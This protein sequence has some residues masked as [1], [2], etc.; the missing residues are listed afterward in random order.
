VESARLIETSPIT[1][2]LNSDASFAAQAR[3]FAEDGA[4]TGSGPLPPAVD[5]TTTY[6]VYW[7]LKNSLHDLERIS[8]SVNL[9]PDVAWMGNTG[10]DIGAVSF[11]ETTRL[12]TWNMEKV[13]TSIP[14]IRAW[15]DLAI[16]PDANDVGTFVKLTNVTAFEGT[17]TATGDTVHAA[18]DALDTELPEDTRAAGKG[19]VT[20]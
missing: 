18:A 6:R 8:V 5:Q 11:H 16:T 14:T 4:V 3:Y 12:I 20:E 7:T 2:A 9:P 15:F 17:D 19:V 1:I 13:P 10:T